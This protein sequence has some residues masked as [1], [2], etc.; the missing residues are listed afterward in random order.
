MVEELIKIIVPVIVGCT[1]IDS[2]RQLRTLAWVMVLSQG[3]LALE[4]N[5]DY[6]AG[7]NRLWLEGYGSL[8]NNGNAVALVACVG[9]AFFLGLNAGRWA[10]KGLAAGLGL[11]MVH[12]IL[13]SFSRGGMLSLVITGF[14][15]FLLVPKRPSAYVAFVLAAL[16]VLRMAGPQVVERFQ[17]AFITQKGVESS[18]D[19]RLTQ[20]SAALRSIAQTPLGVGPD[21]WKLLSSRFGLPEGQAAHST[22]LQVGAELG[23]PG[24][25][26]LLVFYLVCIARLLPMARGRTAVPD[27]WCHHLARMVITSLAG[28]LIA[29]QFV[30]LHKLEI[31]YFVA[32]IGAGLLKLTSTPAA[33]A[34]P[35]VSYGSPYAAA[36]MAAGDDRI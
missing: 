12:A 30:S 13:F 4:F 20:W 22:W 18:A 7:Y 26:C 19:S 36:G 10:L 17:M 28:F 15:A 11:L 33:T 27:P 34:K 24:L 8:D 6:F 29:A 23:L 5:R 21:Q 1:V 2:V 35:A 32:L 31:P 25:G 9:M 14:V 3:Y 16:A